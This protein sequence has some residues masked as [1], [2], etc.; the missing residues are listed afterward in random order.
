MP[1]LLSWLHYRDSFD[2]YQDRK[3]LC[4]SVTFI[5]HFA[6]KHDHVTKCKI[7][8]GHWCCYIPFDTSQLRY[9]FNTVQLAATPLQCGETLTFLNHDPNPLSSYPSFQWLFVDGFD[10]LNCGYLII[11]HCS[12]PVN[13]VF[14]N[15]LDL[16]RT[17]KILQTSVESRIFRISFC[18]NIERK[19]HCLSNRKGISSELLLFNSPWRGPNEHF[20]M[21]HFERLPCLHEV[22]YFGGQNRNLSEATLVTGLPTVGRLFPPRN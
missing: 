11:C 9:F 17:D 20:W 2:I 12:E 1:C 16:V 18:F 3:V 4:A 7:Q 6:W 5:R 22:S 15:G 19:N 10:S 21:T 13:E 8:G 14:T